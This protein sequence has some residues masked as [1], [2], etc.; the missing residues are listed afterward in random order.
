MI[1]NENSI[2][3]EMTQR[4]LVM[5]ESPRESIFTHIKSILALY[6]LPSIFEL[7]DNPPTKVKR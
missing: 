5:K 3:F 4:Q 6:G 7:L 1:R 2:E